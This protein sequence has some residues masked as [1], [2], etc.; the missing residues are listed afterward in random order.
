MTAADRPDNPPASPRL[1]DAAFEQVRSFA[2]GVGTVHPEIMEPLAS[3]G[4]VKPT[5]ELLA[6]CRTL[7]PPPATQ[8]AA[9]P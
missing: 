7:A 2:L 4:Y 1:D 6:T 8:P 5:D 9:T 3:S